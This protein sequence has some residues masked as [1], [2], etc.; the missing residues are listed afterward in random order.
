MLKRLLSKQRRAKKMEKITDGYG[1][2]YSTFAT[3]WDFDKMGFRLPNG[4]QEK[5]F[6]NGISIKWD[7]WPPFQLGG[8][9]GIMTFCF[10]NCESLHGN[11]FWCVEASLLWGN[12]QQSFCW[13]ELAAKW[14]SH[15]SEKLLQEK[16]RENGISN[17]WDFPI[18]FFTFWD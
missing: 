8:L 9:N 4:K 16:Y 13:V 3:K 14:D 10:S 17:K 2:P 6:E 11:C 1:T 12:I 5:Y 7:S 18:E 15:V